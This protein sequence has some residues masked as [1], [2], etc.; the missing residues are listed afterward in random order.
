MRNTMVGLARLV[1]VGALLI[2][3]LRGDGA[4]FDTCFMDGSFTLSGF[5]KIGGSFVQILGVLTFTPGASCTDTG[6]VGGSI[7]LQG[8][9]A[10]PIEAVPNPTTYLVAENGT[11][12][13]SFLGIGATILGVGALTGSPPSMAFNG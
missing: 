4:A 5:G 2:G 9:R 7:I 13:V 1:M 8:E 10:T 3:P 12:K 11:F 6:T